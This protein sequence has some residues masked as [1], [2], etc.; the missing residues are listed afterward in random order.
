VNDSRHRV[1]TG[2]KIYNW[3]SVISVSMIPID[4]VLY[5]LPVVFVFIFTLGG[6]TGI[7]VSN[8]IIDI[9]L[10]DTYYVVSHFHFI[11]SIGAVITLFSG[12]ILINSEILEYLIV[13]RIINIK[14]IF[15]SINLVFTLLY[16]TMF[17]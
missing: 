7:I 4:N 1:P 16:F 14:L 11:L 13:V 8:D 6:L 9:S 2:T 3:I 17:P 10:H 15:I 12:L 5:I